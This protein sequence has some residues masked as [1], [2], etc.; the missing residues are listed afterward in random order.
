[1]D[2]Q[3]EVDDQS[4]ICDET[5]NLV[6]GGHAN[7]GDDQSDQAGENARA[8]R[9]QSES[10][11]NAALFLDAYRRLQRILKYARQAARFFLG[12]SAGDL[13]VAA[14][15]G[16]LNHGRR[17]DH[18]IKHNRKAMVHVRSCNVPKLL[19]ALAVESQMNYPTVSFVGSA[20]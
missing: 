20:C 18:A 16:V 13:C 14:I 8:N 17:L 7:E 19:G 1:A 2:E 6:V 15:N 3:N 10:R 5:W 9:I 4:K 12:K 11:R